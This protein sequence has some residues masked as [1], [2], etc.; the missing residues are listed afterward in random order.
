MLAAIVV[1]ITSILSQSYYILQFHLDGS[2]FTYL[3]LHAES[4]LNDRSV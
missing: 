3:I 4:V 2:D 1:I